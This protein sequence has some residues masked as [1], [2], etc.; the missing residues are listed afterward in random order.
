MSR[1]W[2]KNAIIYSLDV[3]SFMDSDGDGVGDFTGLRHR[4]NYLKHLGV[5]CLWLLPFYDTPNR[6]NGYD[7]RDYYQLDRRLGDLGRFAEFVENAEE[8]GIRV[9]IDL[10]VNHTS[11]E[12]F[13]F[14]E[15]RKN[16]NSRYR[17]F[18]IWADEKPEE[19]GT[20]VIFG[21]EQDGTNWHYDEEAGQYYYHSFYPFQPDLN[22]SNPDVQD[23]IMRI[24][25]FWL[26][27]GISGFRMDAVTHMLRKKGNI[28]FEDDPHDILR[29]FRRSVQ[30][31][32]TDAVLL[33]EVDVDPKRY[34]DFFGDSDQ[35]HMLLNFYINN[36]I[37]LALA[38]REATALAEAI[39]LLPAHAPTEQMANFLRNHDELDLERLSEQEREE[40]FKAFAPKEDMRIY[41]R[42]IRRRLA[43]MLNNDR[44]RLEMVYSLLLTLPGTPL[45][46]YGQEISMGEDLDLKGRDSVRTLMQWNSQKNGGFS[47][48]KQENLVRK[49]IAEGT[50]GY[51]INS[52]QSQQ[53]DSSSFLNW[54]T[55]AINYRKECPEFGKGEVR[56]ME[57]GNKKVLTILRETDSGLALAMHN[58][59]DEDQEIKL[60]LD[61]KEQMLEIFA[62]KEYSR[63]TLENPIEISAYGYRWFREK[64]NFL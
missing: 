32:K 43:P 14:Q 52:V 27:L 17:N 49:S 12:H 11:E 15:A 40:V 30:E 55:R 10:V 46:R 26:K 9:I 54:I 16:K 39:E 25:H 29:K 34:K 41:G 4:L 48:A 31:N 6:D 35:M 37:F 58:F 62:D 22:L 5:D 8:I 24:M 51:K 38:R 19:D 1:F 56:I 2:Y 21:E 36:Y 28:E 64:R 23:E 3:E 47:T 61:Q 44:Q 13:W 33:A 42:G 53:R 59:C 60:D 63:S 20:H 50:N 7:V 18:Y 57:T 45:L